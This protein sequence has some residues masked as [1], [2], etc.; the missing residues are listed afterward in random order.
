[1]SSFSVARNLVATW[2]GTKGSP[3]QKQ[4]KRG[5]RWTY[6]SLAAMVVPATLLLIVGAISGL[7]PQDGEVAR[8]VE[9]GSI[10]ASGDWSAV[11]DALQASLDAYLSEP[12]TLQIG[13]QEVQATAEDLG[14][15]VDYD[16]TEQAVFEVGRGDLF[17][18]T[19]ER[20]TARTTGVEVMPVVRF[21]RDDLMSELT[22]LG[23]GTLRAPRNAGFK[24]TQSGIVVTP[25]A[26]GVGIDTMAAV[27]SLRQAVAEQQTDAITI[28]TVAIKPAVSTHEAE[29]ALARANEL[30][31]RGLVLTDSSGAW[32]LRPE[33]L[34]SA[35]TIRDGEITFDT[36]TLAAVIGSLEGTIRQKAKNA[37][38]VNNGDGTFSIAPAVTDRKLDVE[39]TAE[40]AAEAIMAGDESIE[41]VV[42]EQEPP[43]TGER[44]KPIYTKLTNIV[45]HGV[46]LTWPEGQW[47]MEQAPLA[48]ALIWNPQTGAIG[49][50]QGA[51]TEAIRPGADLASH[52]PTNIRWKGQLITSENSAP[53]LTVD[54]P[55]TVA[56]VNDA[57]LQG[58]STVE[59]VVHQDTSIDPAALGIHIDTTLGYAQSFYGYSSA[60]RKVNV[61]TAVAALDGAMIAPHS[62]F[63]FNEAIGGTASLEDGY[64]MGY[65]IIRN[66]SGDVV[67]VPSVA[68]GIC[69]VST[70]TFQAAFWAG[71]PI[72]QRS[73]HMYWIESYGVGP[74]GMKGLDA[75]VDPASGLDFRFENPTDEWL[76]IRASADGQ[77]VTVELRG[78][79]LG[80]NVAVDGPEIT[81]VVQADQTEYQQFDPSLA[82]GQS[83]RIEVA[84]DGFTASIHRKVTDGNGKLVDENTFVSTYVPSRNVTLVGPES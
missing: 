78:P 70:M 13:D 19:R 75:T 80:W 26:D 77:Y 41:L 11:A 21:D 6:L 35:L 36:D 54:L 45:A 18:S 1:M 84:R 15:T 9:V 63:S 14:M 44:L 48:N 7:P 24:A 16:A 67:T 33:D 38:I 79:N 2:A 37:E 52:P 29:E 42:E 62:T 72:T 50:N 25:A 12:L 8:G 20:F 53:G 74:G 3:K 31:A 56:K 82:P 58:K 27:E 32:R 47:T 60:N 30:A 43:I 40:N 4:P 57:V 68:G 81:D 69:Q 39:A 5:E 46:T 65:G 28:P 71:M 55:A 83:I 51:L 61:E 76:A 64:M 10:E 22:G 73:W 59:M 49:F 23:A 34:A 17:S 66:E